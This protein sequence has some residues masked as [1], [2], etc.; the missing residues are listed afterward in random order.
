MNTI[1]NNGE[2]DQSLNDGLDK[3]GHAYGQLPHE[4][5]PNL[6]DQAILNSAH[7][8]VE[9][10]PH[11]MKFGWLH[12]LTTAAVFVLALSLI[13]QQREQIPVF[14]DG[15]RVNESTGLQREMTA[16]KRSRDT[17]TDDLR[18]EL[19]E[20]NEKRQDVFRSAPVSTASQDEAMEAVAGDQATEPAASGRVSSY[21]SESLKV[22]TDSADKDTVAIEPA[23]E[24]IVEE[25]L[26][27]EADSVADAPELENMYKQSRPAAIAS[28]VA[29]EAE[30]PADNE[31]EIEQKLL[32]ILK[33]KQS[34]DEAWITELALFKQDYPGYPLPDELSN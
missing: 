31:S 34:G 23:N 3:L 21:V 32:A 30:A 28:P 20:E 4:E 14:E 18:L 10:K 13:F 5:P 17:Q 27:D 8:A 6:L 15:V 9:K 33:L 2:N 24:P 12:G 26:A 1:H 22:K 7:R 29:S 11:W 19:K 16:K 25:L